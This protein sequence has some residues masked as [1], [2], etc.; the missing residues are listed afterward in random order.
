MHRMEAND[1]HAL[2]STTEVARRLG[3]ARNTVLQRVAYGH[4]TPVHRLPGKTGA[5]LFDAE[6]IA[7]AAAERETEAAR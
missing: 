7:A 6:Q 2:L 1:S 4:L 3:I 5:Y